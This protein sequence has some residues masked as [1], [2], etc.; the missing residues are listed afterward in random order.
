VRPEHEIIF[1]SQSH[2]ARPPGM[3]V[4]QLA[5]A[6]AFLGLVTLLTAPGIPMIYAGQE[7]GEDSPRT[8]DFQPLHWDK[9]AQPVYQSYLRQVKRLLAIR[10]THAALASDHIRFYAND[11]ANEQ[12]LRFERVL[13][14][15][16]GRK[17]LDFVVV[18]LNF[19]GIARTV[20][21]PVPWSGRWQDL[22]SEE[23]YSIER[24]SLVELAPWQAMVL[25]AT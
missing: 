20:E 11:F 17:A 22:L 2:I 23:V 12:V 9:L 10:R 18:A 19:G 16:E 5:R 6:K 14:D 13:Y 24:C 8:I 25:A 7:F 21:L 1:Y 3:T 15:E 4:Q